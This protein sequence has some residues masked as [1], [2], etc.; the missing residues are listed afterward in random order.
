MVRQPRSA[1]IV[2]GSPGK[3]GEDGRG[4]RLAGE[5]LHGAG[6][7]DNALDAHDHGAGAVLAMVSVPLATIL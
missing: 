7:R 1:G 2:R 5:A 3:G 4:L 6:F